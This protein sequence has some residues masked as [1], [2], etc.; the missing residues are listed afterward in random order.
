[1]L[2]CGAVAAA[3]KDATLSAKALGDPSWTIIRG[4][5]QRMEMDAQEDN[6]DQQIAKSGE[7]QTQQDRH[8]QA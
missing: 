1:M 3:S 5:T 6:H 2:A 4:S 8:G 7:Q